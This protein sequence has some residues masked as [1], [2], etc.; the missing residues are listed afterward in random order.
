MGIST[1]CA[2]YILWMLNFFKDK[3]VLIIANTQDVAM[4]LIKK[5]KIMYENLPVWFKEQLIV[6]NKQSLVFANNSSIKAAAA[7]PNAGVSQALSL[8]VFDQAAVLNQALAHQIWNSS[9]PCLS[10]LVDSSQVTV[11]NKQ[12]GEIN[13]ISLKELYNEM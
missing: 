8:L 10:C 5:I 2:G 9:Q 1:L 7:T 6:D 4:N 13:T 11:R 3:T 12:T